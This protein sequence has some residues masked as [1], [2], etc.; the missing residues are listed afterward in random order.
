[1]PGSESG[2]TADDKERALE[3]VLEALERARKLGEE[4]LRGGELE[5][6]KVDGFFRMY[7][8]VEF[9]IGLGKFLLEEKNSVGIFREISVSKKND[10]QTMPLGRLRDRVKAIDSDLEYAEYSFET[11]STRAALETARRA[12]DELKMLVLANRKILPRS[13]KNQSPAST[14]SAE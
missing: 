5:L 13:W 11:G 9:S 12:R 4:K 2:S 8:E 10:P 7:S 3:A 14:N 6:R 1:V